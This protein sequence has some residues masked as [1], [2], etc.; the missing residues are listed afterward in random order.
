MHR[1]LL[2]AGLGQGRKSIAPVQVS[3]EPAA[4]DARRRTR[5]G[6]RI[7]S[8]GSPRRVARA[9]CARGEV[10][11][12]SCRLRARVGRRPD[13]QANDTLKLT[14]ARVAASG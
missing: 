2:V 1:E 10:A 6:S 9:D 7:A 14:S 8:G 3:N 4:P 12:R 5:Y 11:D 13:L